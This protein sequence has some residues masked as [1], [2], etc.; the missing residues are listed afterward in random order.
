MCYVVSANRVGYDEDGF[1]APWFGTSM[2]VDPHGEVMVSAGDTNDEVVTAEIDPALV[3]RLRTQ[4]GY[5]RERRP[6]LYGKSSS[7]SRQGS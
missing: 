4:W 1:S 3:G 6:D 7:S 5:F 2:I